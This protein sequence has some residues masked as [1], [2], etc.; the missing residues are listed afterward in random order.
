MLRIGGTAATTVQ[1]LSALS[2][3]NAMSFAPIMIGRMKLAKGPETM[4]M[5][6]MIITMPWM[7]TIEL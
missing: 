5:V 1:K 6:A 7:V 3:G 4:M 2:R